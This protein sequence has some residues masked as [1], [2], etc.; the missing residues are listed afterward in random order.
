[1]KLKQLKCKLT[2]IIITDKN[3]NESH[4]KT[5]D[6]SSPVLLAEISPVVTV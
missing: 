2:G 1:M 6:I 3:I 4:L 5:V